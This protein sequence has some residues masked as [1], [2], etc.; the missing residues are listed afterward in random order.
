MKN[1]LSKSTAK[2][3]RSFLNT[4]LHIDA[5]SSSCITLFQPKAPKELSKFRRGK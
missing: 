2:G 3:I 5:N 4:F 1:K